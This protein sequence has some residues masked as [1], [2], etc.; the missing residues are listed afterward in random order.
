MLYVGWTI[1]IAPLHVALFGRL[2]LEPSLACLVVA[3]ST[4]AVTALSG[5]AIVAVLRAGRPQ[6]RLWWLAGAA[7]MAVLTG[8]G[9]LGASR[10][11]SQVA[12]TALWLGY[13]LATL[14][15]AGLAV[16][17]E[18]PIDLAEVGPDRSPAAAA[19]PDT[20][21]IQVALGT[22]VVASLARVAFWR[23]GV[24]AIS[25]ILTA[26]AAALV[27][28]RYVMAS[29]D[30]S[31]HARRYR[32]MAYTD[33]LTGLANRRALML[34]TGQRADRE[35]DQRQQALLTIDLDGFKDVND[36][37]GHDVGDHVLVQVANRLMAEVG[38][39]DL[40]I[41]LGGDE[42]AVLMPGDQAHAEQVARRL[43]EQLAQPYPITSARGIGRPAP[44]RL[45]ASVGLAW[46]P[47]G[48]DVSAL[49]RNA[50]ISLRFAKL[51]GKD[52]I[53]RYDAAY[54]QWLRR[55][56]TLEQELRGAD[57][58]GELGLVYQPVV[59]LHDAPAPVA[60]VSGRTVIGVEALLRWHHPVLGQISPAEFIPVAEEV[61][62]VAALDR[63]VLATAVRQ[64]AS[65]L[66]AGHD[67]WAAVNISV[68]DLRDPG[69][70]RQVLAELERHQVP[71]HRLVLEVTE[72]AIAVDLEAIASRLSA[73]RAAGVRIAL[74]DF[75]AGY[76]ALGQL[77]RIPIDI[78]KMDHDLI[79]ATRSPAGGSVVPLVD[80]VVQLGQRLGLVVI[81]EG[82]A[83]PEQLA[84]VQAAN[85]PLGQGE[86]FWG[87]MPADQIEPLLRP[88][89]TEAA[90][91]L[92]PV[93][94]GRLPGQRHGPGG[95]HGHDS[96][97]VDSGRSMR[98]G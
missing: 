50:D 40:V 29:R 8:A 84:V 52:R 72:H 22:V 6:G 18:R 27:N 10:Y 69:Y 37:R 20:A 60:G 12:A 31:G 98:Q 43:L 76:S 77:R 68:R 59:E 33:A 2:V 67:V 62:L 23:Q 24:D 4:T 3:L 49:L 80:V 5:T 48:T 88:A 42:F 96:G 57:E 83:E 70:A 38:R 97:Q 71:P 11:A 9:A 91:S 44:V 54:D 14:A 95:R 82:V 55:R 7:V 75:G 58:R 51:R 65:W 17:A 39:D 81:A 64:L 74:D 56:N 16:R 89:A 19:K 21:V 73:L 78:L 61:G 66:S 63:W 15:V 93:A 90:A 86:L 30:L 85:C 32:Q 53:E 13:G 26:V 28:V 35:F 92:S 25:V 34:R 46:S 45:T 94:S 41:R 79:G 47:G 87:A 1:L 36:M